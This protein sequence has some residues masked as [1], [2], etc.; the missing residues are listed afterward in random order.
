MQHH[1]E[2]VAD[3]A[4]DA[5]RLERIVHVDAVRALIETFHA[6]TGHAVSI[7]D[8][9]DRFLARVGWHEACTRFH[10][11]T[12]E[13]CE[14]CRQSDLEMTEG[15]ARG[16]IRAYHCKNGLWHVVTPLFVGD[17]HLGNVFTSQFFYDDE[18][19]DV[20]GF[21]ARADL[22]GWD[23]DEYL[24]A[25]AAIPRYSRATIDSLMRFYALLTEQIAVLGLTNLQLEQTMAARETALQAR[26]DSEMRFSALIEGAPILI[27][28]TDAQERL[29]YVNDEFTRV[30]G[31]TVEDV[32]TVGE[33]FRKAFPGVAERSEAVA[34]RLADIEAGRRGDRP[35]A[36]HEHAIVSKNGDVRT[37]TISRAL[38]GDHML[39]LM[40]DVTDRKR[41]EEALEL[42][43]A[44]FAVAYRT[45]PDAVNI[46]RLSDG[47]Y[48]DVNDGFTNLTGYTAD[49]VAGRTSSDIR[50]WAD[51]ADRDR[52][53]AAL[54]ANGVVSNLEA[55]F[56]R[57]DGILT[58]ALM[59]ARTIEIDGEPC[60][61]SVT[62]D[63]SDRKHAELLLS[64]SQRIA[65]VGHYEWDIVH[66]HWD[67]SE[68][69][70]DI[71][72][73]DESYPRDLAGFLG[74]VHP[75]ERDAV[76]AYVT[77][78]VV[79]QRTN[80]DREYRIVRVCDGAERWVHGLGDI[81]YDEGGTPLALFGI[82]QDITD[83]KRS[84]E[85]IREGNAAIER[86]VYDFA[87]TMG[88]IVEARDPYTQGHQQCVAGLCKRIAVR[89]G[90]APDAVDEVEMAG[91]LHDVGKLRVPTE[92]LTKPGSLSSA[93]FSL[94]KEHPANGRE[95]L[96]AIAF[97]WAVAE[98]AWQHHERMDGSGYPRGLAGDEILL[99]ARILAAADVVEAMA[100]H[101]P[102]RPA[103][104]VDD[105]VAEVQA[106]PAWFDPDV[107]EA[108]AALHSEG[109][110]GL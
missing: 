93:E 37:V 72:G 8:L 28:V 84:D 86:M 32:P 26:E 79:G 61:L 45:S 12:P 43:E 77:D 82:I 80:F 47:M 87:E 73:I 88:L 104:P 20:A 36:R 30:L 17:R 109:E 110:L 64:E 23:R 81:T 69:L 53:V 100:S 6:L 71:F 89:M 57:K 63:I 25:I 58:T 83:R 11:A 92:I 49:D 105:A 70:M 54:R 97:P 67:A 5:V 74:I 94:I 7:A 106:H 42:S 56:R 46:N 107:V 24:A 103:F 10:R 50:I 34:A 95:I 31:Y 91:L 1:D 41:A 9:D 18:T 76:G 65:G 55:R 85:A 29:E 68:V 52:L 99:A 39:V 60:I 44:K 2:Q 66:D 98:I 33:W 19:V 15:V 102:Y 16:E 78:Q 27:A 3:D 90:L 14:L 62:R 48:M 22:F 101:R 13:S 108:I 75:D 38:S 96:G 21:E 51:D 40:E 4:L 35:I 59:S